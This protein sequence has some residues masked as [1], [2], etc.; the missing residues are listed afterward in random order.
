M[1]GRGQRRTGRAGGVPCRRL[2]G[3]G[4]DG[5]RTVTAALP[6]TV[7]VTRPRHPLEG[8]ELR[9]LGGMH[10]HGRLELLLVLPD[11]SKR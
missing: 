9:V 10:R 4:G 3:L 5:G 6:A 2:P 1:L 7:L 11:G 8:R